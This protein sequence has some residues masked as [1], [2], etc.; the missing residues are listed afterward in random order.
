MTPQKQPGI[1]I[2]MEYHYMP[3]RTDQNKWTKHY[4]EMQAGSTSQKKVFR[5]K[6]NHKAQESKDEPKINILS[7]S[8]QLVDQAKE[9]IKDEKS[10][11]FRREIVRPEVAER[12]P[13]GKRAKS[14]VLKVQHEDDIFA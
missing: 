9:S 14:K 7:E 4:L 12:P 5:I 8:K 13:P 1:H 3:H 10:S 11:E 2:N 6:Y